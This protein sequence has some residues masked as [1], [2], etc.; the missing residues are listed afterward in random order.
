V[1]GGGG[2][3]VSVFN[4]ASSVGEASIRRNWAA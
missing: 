4:E 2:L 3:L 1:F